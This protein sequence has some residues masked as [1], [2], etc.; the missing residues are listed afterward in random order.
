[1][2]KMNKLMA[3]ATALVLACSLSTVAFA[4][5][6][7]AP[8][9]KPNVPVVDNSKDNVVVGQGVTADAA[10]AEGVEMIKEA[11]LAQAPADASGFRVDKAFSLTGTAGSEVKVEMKLEAGREYNVMHVHNGKVTVEATKRVADG[12]VFT[13]ETFSDFAVVSYVRAEGGSNPPADGETATTPAAPAAPTAGGVPTSPKTGVEF[14][15]ASIVAVAALAGAAF[16][17]KKFSVKE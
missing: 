3:V 17:A 7:T 12:V 1:M 4:A 10:T 5:S 16:C 9:V 13:P 11:L 8:D 15:M 6:E 14:P 2:K